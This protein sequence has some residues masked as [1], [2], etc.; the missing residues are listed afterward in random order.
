[1]NTT[2][3]N[4]T[5]TDRDPETGAPETVRALYDAGDLPLR[6]HRYAGCHRGAGSDGGHGW[7]DTPPSGRLSIRYLERTGYRGRASRVPFDELPD[8]KTWFTHPRLSF[9]DYTNTGPEERANVETFVTRHRETDGV[10]ETYGAYGAR[11]VAVRGDVS[12]PAV[13][14]DLRRVA[15]PTAYGRPVLDPDAVDR[16]RETLR[17]EAV[18]GWALREFWGHVEEFACRNAVD[19]VNTFLS[20]ANDADADRVRRAR[21]AD[22][23]DAAVYS[24]L[25][26]FPETERRR[27]FERAVDASGAQF[28]FEST[29]AHIDTERVA[30]AV[31]IHCLTP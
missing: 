19:L 1:M 31:Q 5:T 28:I 9:G 17:T 13:L 30:D 2:T 4:N 16:V 6:A 12:D 11:G 21:D 15:G 8:E 25:D 20:F 10:R 26:A 27:L 29:G 24:I 14:R 7:T 22:G 18:D 3:D 23:L